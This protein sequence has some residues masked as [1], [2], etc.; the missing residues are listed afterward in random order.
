M[1]TSSSSKGPKG[2]VSF[3]PPWLDATIAAIGNVSVPL[4]STTQDASDFAP[5]NRFTA[6]RRNLGIYM[7]SGES[8]SLRKAIGHYVRHG[9]GG[10]SR[11]AG[12]MKFVAAVGAK[13]LSLFSGTQSAEQLQ[14][15]TK[16]ETLLASSH[17]TEDVIS[18]IVDFVMPSSGTVDEET[19]R[20]AMAE[21]LSD[22]LSER[23]D[24]DI[25]A[26]SEDDRWALL[27]H[28]VGK[29]I[30]RQLILDIGQIL[31][32]DAISITTKI[33]RL[34]EMEQFVQATV[35]ESFHN[36]RSRNANISQDDFSKIINDVLEI[37]FQVFG[38]DN[39]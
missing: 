10:A 33:H 37:T 31:E 24:M 36:I 25:A 35:T 17:T 12:K 9:L 15:K 8:Q 19:C 2:G 28:F 23:S 4:P 20:D 1:G 6:A 13:T 39:E 14:F 22:L 5:S 11:A 27:E 3:D 26:L 32:S 21:A 29:A 7:R 38:E 30:V 34:E 16:I 18:T